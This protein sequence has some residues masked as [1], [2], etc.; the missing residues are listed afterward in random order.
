VD[1][2]EEF[3]LFAGLSASADGAGASALSWGTLTLDFDTPDLVAASA[4][5]VPAAI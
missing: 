1:K 4:V 3:Y 5:R 2:G